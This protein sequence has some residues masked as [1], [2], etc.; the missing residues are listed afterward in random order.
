MCENVH[1]CDRIIHIL[2]LLAVMIIMQVE[3]I[4]ESELIQKSLRTRE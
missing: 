3:P 4:A 2:S 1:L